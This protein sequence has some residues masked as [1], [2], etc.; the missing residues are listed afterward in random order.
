MKRDLLKKINEYTRG[1]HRLGVVHRYNDIINENIVDGFWTGIGSTK[2][3]GR[4]YERCASA[5][6]AEV[7][8]S[9]VL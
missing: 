2:K 4:M 1:F 8:G 7:F 3:N 6:F 9:L 5:D